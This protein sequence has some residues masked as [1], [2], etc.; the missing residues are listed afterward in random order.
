MLRDEV[1]EN[2]EIHPESQILTKMK[3][4]N[5]ISI[6]ASGISPDPFIVLEHLHK[7]SLAKML[8]DTR[9]S[10]PGG[11][12]QLKTSL[13]YAR[14]IIDALKYLHQD[15]SASSTIVHADLRPE[16]IGF[17]T[18]NELKI[19]DFSN[20][21]CIQKGTY[22]RDEYEMVFHN[23][24]LAYIAPEVVLCLPFNEK[25][26]IYSFGIILWELLS[27]EAPF[28]DMD[29]VEHTEW[30]IVQGI[31]PDLKDTNGHPLIHIPPL[32]SSMIERCWDDEP[33]RR[34][35]CIE[36]AAILEEQ[37]R[38]L[39]LNSR[40]PSSSTSSSSHP[41]PKKSI[42]YPIPYNPSPY[43]PNKGHS[44]K[45]SSSSSLNSALNKVFVEDFVDVEMAGED[46]TIVSTEST[47][48]T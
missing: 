27:G 18:N 40:I 21:V 48:Y 32:L 45:S 12:L 9:S 33:H 35:S 8:S 43:P 25:A 23:E 44:N 15:N 37:E 28:P 22:F 30:F 19:F 2:D 29:E 34:P 24:N 1:M 5:I 41:N 11:R 26:D 14:Q 42:P 17:T 46:S 4:P 20:S 7:G 10:T 39:G 13:S 3:H 16:N 6:L 47:A 31:R 36:I 38:I